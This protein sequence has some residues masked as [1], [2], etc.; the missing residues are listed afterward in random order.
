VLAATLLALG[1]AALHTGWNLLVK[2]SADRLMAMWGQLL[3]GGLIFLPWLPLVGPPGWDVLPF[4]ACSCVVHGIYALALTR[5]YRCGDFSFAYPVARGGGALVAAAAG[6]V[7]LGDQL[8]AAAWVAIAVA[9]GGLICLA[10]A[11]RT[12]SALLWA[13][14]TAAAI[15]TYTS[16]DAAGAR[17][18]SGFGYGIS[19]TLGAG[20]GLTLALAAQGRSRAMWRTVAADWPRCF[21]GGAASALA[22]SMVLTGARLAPVGYVAALREVSVVLAAAAGWLLLHERQGRRRVA[23]AVTVAFGLALLVAFR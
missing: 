19:V 1:S 14:L 18:S 8:S 4:L 12:P 17:A 20:L 5:A 7:F 22:Y 23:S 16:V 13:G 9:A 21:A 15:G 11:G 10:G 6:V 3:A 2:T